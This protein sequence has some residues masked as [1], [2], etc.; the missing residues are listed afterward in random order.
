MIDTLAFA[1]VALALGI[2][3]LIMATMAGSNLNFDW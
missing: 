3:A 2:P 1:F